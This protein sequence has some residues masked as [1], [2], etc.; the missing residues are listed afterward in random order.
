MCPV[1]TRHEWIK[2]LASASPIIEA[3]NLQGLVPDGELDRDGYYLAND[4]KHKELIISGTQ[5][6]TKRPSAT[7]TDVT[8]ILK[9]MTHRDAYGKY[10]RNWLRMIG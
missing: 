10:F 6:L 2:S 1:K 5:N 4:D 7:S 8:D 9:N 3:M